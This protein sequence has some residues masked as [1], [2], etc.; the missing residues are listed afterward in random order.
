MRLSHNTYVE[1]IRAD[2]ARIAAVAARGLEV[3]VPSCPGWTV[4]D[5]VEHTAETYRHKIACMQ[6]KAFPDPWPPE[7][8]DEPALGS[9]L[10]GL[11]QVDGHLAEVATSAEA[12]L[13]RLA[14]EPNFS[15]H[16]VTARELYNLVKAA[17]AGWTGTVSEA[18][19]F[20]LI[21]EHCR[22]AIQP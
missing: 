13:E 4:R 21:Q 6:E 11:L 14:R 1:H 20:A 5:L 3:A 8:D 12:A 19:D 22:V 7:R 9:V 17:E 16:Y 10:A 18:R 15:F 2:A